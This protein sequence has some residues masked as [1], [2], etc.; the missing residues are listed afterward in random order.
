MRVLPENDSFV[1]RLLRDF[2][3]VED[4]RRFVARLQG[5]GRFGSSVLPNRKNRKVLVEPLAWEEW[6]GTRP[7]FARR[8]LQA[9]RL[10]YLAFS[11]LPLLLVVTSHF[12]ANG[13]A[14]ATEALHMVLATTL[15]HLGCNLWN[16]YEDHLRGVDSPENSGG[17]GVIRKLW[18]PAVHIRNAAAAMFLLGIALGVALL[19]R[20]EWTQKHL[21][22]IGLL[23]AIGAASYSGWPFHYKYLGLGEPVVFLLGGPLIAMGATAVMHEDAD[24]FLWYA[25]AS[26]PLSFLAVLRLHTNNMQRAPFDAMAGARTI[27][28]LAGFKLSRWLTVWLLLAPFLAALALRLSGVAPG[29]SWISAL[30]LPLLARPLRLALS[31]TGPLDP[32]CG[33][34]RRSV[35][36][37]HLAFGLMWILGYSV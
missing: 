3:F 16:D 9:L 25:L 22:W 18:I 27:A 34:L 30:A 36:R 20:L 12:G 29:A 8:W 17:S 35:A 2:R 23:G 7:G 11:L 13:L 4:G 37:L 32:A 6:R 28:S 5:E 15:L 1:A 24:F 10:P 31:C 26:L 21:L 19:L 33:D 14:R